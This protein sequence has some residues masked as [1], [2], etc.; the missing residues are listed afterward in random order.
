[1]IELKSDLIEKYLKINN[2]IIA[3][4]GSN[5]CKH[6]LEL[7]PKLFELS[8]Q[9]PSREIIYIDCDKFPDSAD[10][11][12]V[13]WY[14]TVIHFIDQQAVYRNITDRINEIKELWS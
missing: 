6:C 12:D 4:F 2:N 14:P 5:S 8:Q 10:L 3:V 11:Y 9:F 13:Q 7:K 1:M